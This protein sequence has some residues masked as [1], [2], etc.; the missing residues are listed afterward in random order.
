MWWRGREG[1]CRALLPWALYLALTAAG[2][3]EHRW[4]HAPGASAASHAV[5]GGEEAARP[6]DALTVPGAVSPS[7]LAAPR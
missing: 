5:W 7:G 3:A 6:V 2:W 1:A 4:P